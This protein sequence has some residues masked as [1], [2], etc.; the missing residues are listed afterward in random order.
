MAVGKKEKI[1]K[2]QIKEGKNKVYLF[3]QQV[4]RIRDILLRRI[5]IP[6]SLH[7]ITDP[8]LSSFRPLYCF[9]AAGEKKKNCCEKQIKEGKKE[10]GLAIFIQPVFRIRYTGLL[11]ILLFSSVFFKDA[12]KK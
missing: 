4:F 3:L 10:Q 5:R 11:R 8:A 6:G 7:W 12:N 9:M 2:K 1:V